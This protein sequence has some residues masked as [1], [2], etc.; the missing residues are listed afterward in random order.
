LFI[1]AITQYSQVAKDLNFVRKKLVKKNK[2][3][4]IVSEIK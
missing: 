4:P 1:D 2:V 3:A